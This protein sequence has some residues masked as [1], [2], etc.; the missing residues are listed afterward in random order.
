MG[1]TFARRLHVFTHRIDPRID[2]EREKIV[3]DLQLTGEVA[4]T[5]LVDRP[6]PPEPGADATGETLETDGRM[7]LVVL[8]PVEDLPA[9]ATPL[10]SDVRRADGQ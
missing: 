2:G 4:A 9:A 5:A 6:R 8:R 10:A 7:A 3:N 1:I